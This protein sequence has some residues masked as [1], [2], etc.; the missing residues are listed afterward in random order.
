MLPDRILAK[1]AVLIEG[2][3]IREVAVRDRISAANTQIIEHSGFICPGLVDLGA[4]GGRGADFMDGT[5]EAFQTALLTHACHGVT[6]VVPAATRA[7]TEW[8]F[9]F[10]TTARAMMRGAPSPIRL[11][12]A[13]LANLEPERRLNGESEGARHSFIALDATELLS[14]ADVIRAV[15]IAPESEGAER[16]AREVTRAGIAVHIAESDASFEEVEAAIGWGARH[17]RRLFRDMSDRDHKVNELPRRGGLVEASLY[18]DELTTD[19]IADGRY[20]DRSLLLLAYKAKGPDRLALVSGATRAVDMPDGEYL[21]GPKQAGA[22]FLKQGGA[23]FSLD[24]Q[25]WVQSVHGLDHMVRTFLRATGAPLPHVIRMASLTPARILG[26]QTQLGS[27]EPGK[28]AD[29]VLFD[30][31]LC[32]KSVWVAGRP[33]QLSELLEV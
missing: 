9:P 22:P 20:L 25:R 28:F 16:W 26:R 32:V 29:L 14:F 23:G 24:G 8:L 17:V 10:L 21:F 11:L 4:H 1:G 2:S 18:F 7:D 19:L 6:S 15:A 30:D 31:D 5:A 13:H 27:I 12:G 33:V 3:W